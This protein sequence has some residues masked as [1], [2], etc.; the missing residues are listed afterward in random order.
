M[1]ALQDTKIKNGNL[2]DLK[3]ALKNSMVKVGLRSQNWPQEEEKALLISHIIKEFGNHTV[4]EIVMAF[5][6]AID[7]QLVFHEGDKVHHDATCYENFSC[8]YFSK[9]MNAYRVWA[10]NVYK[11]HRMDVDN[12]KV[13]STEDTG[14]VAME[15]WLVDVKRNLT[16]LEFMPIMLYDWLDRKGRIAKTPREKNEFLE[17]AV[18][19]RHGQLSKSFS[20]DPKRL[21]DLRA[22][23]AM[24]QTGHFEGIEVAKLKDLAKKMILKE[25]IDGIPE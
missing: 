17:K 2:D 19:Y 9:I 15:A 22:F 5:E 14:D 1:L 7:G 11:Q 21:D 20:E 13:E 24:K 3:G 10:S 18:A 4:K 8:M 16:H 6:L 23:N 25:Y 12:L